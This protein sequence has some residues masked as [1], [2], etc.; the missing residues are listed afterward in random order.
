[1]EANL[2]CDDLHYAFGGD[3]LYLNSL[4]ARGQSVNAIEVH[5][6]HGWM[7]VRRFYF[8]ELFIQELKHRF[9]IAIVNP[10]KNLVSSLMDIYHVLR[11]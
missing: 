4:H 5:A 1:M 10:V 7:K 8:Y 6:V 3:D 11:I 2:V 9:F